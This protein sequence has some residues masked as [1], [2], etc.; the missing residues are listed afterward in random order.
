MLQ[1]VFYR[2]HFA[3]STYMFTNVRDMKCVCL[4][5]C[6]NWGLQRRQKKKSLTSGIVRWKIYREKKVALLLL[7]KRN[8]VN[9]SVK[10]IG[11]IGKCLWKYVCV[12]WLAVHFFSAFS[13]KFSTSQHKHTLFLSVFF[14]FSSLLFVIIIHSCSC[15][16]FFILFF[17]FTLSICSSC[18]TRS[19]IARYEYVSMCACACICRYD[20]N[21]DELRIR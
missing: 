9:V 19:R 15:C 11:K 18:E 2:I 10:W 3:H 1:F 8:I 13:R 4:S 5:V 7:L 14:L 16:F 6:V 20:T 17:L 12:Q 21:K